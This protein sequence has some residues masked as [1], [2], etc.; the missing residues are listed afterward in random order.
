MMFADDVKI[1]PNE[2]KTLQKLLALSKRWSTSN[3]MSWSTWKCTILTPRVTD[4][5]G[6]YTLSGET[7]PTA[8]Q[9]RY[10]GYKI[11]SSGVM[12]QGSAERLMMARQRL[13]MMKHAGIFM[14]NME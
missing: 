7:I 8:K 11:T 9:K 1:N 12:A 13:Y 6:Q 10:L 5:N 3:D 14:R 4:T 2:P